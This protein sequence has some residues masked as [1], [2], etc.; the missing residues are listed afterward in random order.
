MTTKTIAVIGGAGLIG[1]QVVALLSAAGHRVGGHSRRSGADAAVGVGLDSALHGVEVVV[2]VLNS[3]STDDDRA[4]TFFTATA[5]N[6]ALAAKRARVRHYVLLS[7]VGVDRM[8][9]P[10][11]LRGKVLQER[12]IEASGIPFTVIR[13]TQF[14][15]LAEFIVAGQTV[16]GV[17]RAPDAL[18][19]PIASAD[20]ATVIARVAQAPPANR[21][22]ELAGPE[23]MTFAALARSVLAHQGR[24][25]PVV[26]DA[27][28]TYFGTPVSRTSLVP[29]GDAELGTTRL[30]TWLG[31]RAK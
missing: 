2:D 18:I 7:I 5:A 14:H 13:A 12:T 6:L 29:V 27:T 20:V 25:L 9:G 17:V 4:L 22:L 16:D 23:S 8:H 30:D 26:T 28:A 11:Y 1:A 3:P 15:E 19:Q 24:E 21:V 10:G 31:L